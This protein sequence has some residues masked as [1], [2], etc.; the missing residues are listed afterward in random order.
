MVLR[1]I[2]S[3]AREAKFQDQIMHTKFKTIFLES[4][5]LKLQLLAKRIT[6]GKD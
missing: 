5:S 6:H 4:L 1:Q 2:N 3:T